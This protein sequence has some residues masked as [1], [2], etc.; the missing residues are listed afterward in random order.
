MNKTKIQKLLDHWLLVIETGENVSRT[1]AEQ[2]IGGLLG[3]IKRTTGQPVVFDIKTHDNQ[4]IIQNSLCHEIP[5]WSDLI[6]SQ[7][8]LMD[9][10]SWTRGDFIQLY[11]EHFRLVVEKLQRIVDRTTTENIDNERNV[12]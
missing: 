4:T 10:Y 8:A 3:R 6:R 2:I 11:F 9:G 1:K 12:N 5:Q 7:P